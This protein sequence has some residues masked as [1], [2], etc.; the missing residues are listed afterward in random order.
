MG[1]KSKIGRLVKDPKKTIRHTYYRIDYSA[2]K[3]LFGNT[4]GLQNNVSGVL[5]NIG[6]DAPSSELALELKTKGFVSLGKIYDDSFINSIK[7]KYDKMIEDDKYSFARIGHEGHVFTRQLRNDPCPIQEFSQ[8]FSDK[9]KGIMTEYFGGNFQIKRLIASRNYHIPPEIQAKREFYADHWHC[10]ARDVDSYWKV[11][12]LLSDVTDDDG[13]LHLHPRERTKELIKMGF[14]T[15]DDYKLSDD[16]LYDPQYLVKHTG[17]VG[18]VVI[19]NPA[20]CLHRAGVPSSGRTRDM[21]Y[22]IM[23]RS[24]EPFNED[25]LNHQDP[26]HK[27]D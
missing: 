19:G 6:K 7:S 20:I 8:L 26:D 5:K 25:W 2:G 16:I 10:D 11:F 15:R 21:V 18:T 12:V 24:K 22:L 27:Y 9:I 14:G 4:A 3:S 13:P 17:P 1:I 23:S